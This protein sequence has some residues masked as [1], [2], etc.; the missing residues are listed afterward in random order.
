MPD[1]KATPARRR[2]RGRPRRPDPPWASHRRA[3]LAEVQREPRWVLNVERFLA[4][5][6][7]RDLTRRIAGARRSGN[8]AEAQERA[9]ESE[10][11]RAELDYLSRLTR[12]QPTPPEPAPAAPSTAPPPSPVD[13]AAASAGNRKKTLDD[14]TSN[15]GSVERHGVAAPPRNGQ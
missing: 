3:A 14:R 2:P 6:R 4:L 10:R 7:L 13:F 12:N 15:L 5:A 8:L 9:R 11:V 1:A